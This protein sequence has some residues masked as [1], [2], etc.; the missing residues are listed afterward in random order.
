MASLLENFGRL[1]GIEIL[2]KNE[3]E[4]KKEIKSFTPEVKDDGAIAVVA[5]G[6][7]G[8]Y[9][10]MEGTVRTE[11]EIVSRYRQMSLYP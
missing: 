1:F 7:F 2:D 4:N 6:V 9:L 3:E 10:D 11:S 8:T 5:G